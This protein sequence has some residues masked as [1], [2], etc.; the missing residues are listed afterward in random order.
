MKAKLKHSHIPVPENMRDLEVTDLGYLKPWFVKG[1]DF[2][3]VD[4]RKAA[5]AVTKKACWVCGKPFKEARYAM[6]CSESSARHLVF[7]EPPCHVECA[8]YALQVCPFILYPNARRREANLPEEVHLNAVNENLEIKID[9]DNPGEYYL[10]E[11]SDFEF[12]QEKQ[13]MKCKPGD[14]VSTQHWI[15]GVLQS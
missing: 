13:V 2:R 4:T 3:V 14:V 5:F 10:V 6:V 7:K 11:V 15:G 8:E 9:P 1:D 12:L